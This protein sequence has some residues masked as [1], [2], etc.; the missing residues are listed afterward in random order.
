GSLGPI[1]KEYPHGI[2]RRQPDDDFAA[3]RAGGF[4]DQRRMAAPH[5]EPPRFQIRSERQ[6]AAS[7]AVRLRASRDPERTGART[8]NRL[9]SLGGALLASADDQP[10][11]RLALPALARAPVPARCDGLA[12]SA[13]A[14]AVAPSRA[15]TDDCAAP[16]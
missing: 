14:A 15:W 8:G 10:G 3:H 12:A 11:I 6:R 13:A 2:P 9:P 16:G 7:R 5:P 1:R 4:R